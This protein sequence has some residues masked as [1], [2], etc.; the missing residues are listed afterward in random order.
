MTTV[1]LQRDLPADPERVWR[2]LTDPAELAAWYWPERMAPAVECDPVVG[3][4][5]RIASAPD[6]TAVGGRFLAVARPLSLSWTWRWDGEEH[7][8]VV[9]VTLAPTAPELDTPD[10]TRLHLLHDG[11]RPEDV[12]SHREGWV[13]CLDRLPAHLGADGSERA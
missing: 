7:E 6:G 8:S 1:E 5:W 9:A 11:L 2:A 3:G 12:G 10:G 13:S 4:A